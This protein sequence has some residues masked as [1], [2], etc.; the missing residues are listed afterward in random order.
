MIL[1]IDDSSFHTSDLLMSSFQLELFVEVGLVYPFLL[2]L[3]AGSVILVS[4]DGLSQFADL[5]F[6]V[7]LDT[8]LIHVGK[9]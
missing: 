7:F 3:L 6:V 8:L 4:F 5:S 9:I 2:Q 1:L